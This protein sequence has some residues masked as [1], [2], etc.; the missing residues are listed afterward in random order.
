MLSGIEVELRVGIEDHRDAPDP[1]CFEK[2]DSHRI[3]CQIFRISSSV[4]IENFLGAEALK[5]IG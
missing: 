4:E 1:S 5:K 2:A 3:V